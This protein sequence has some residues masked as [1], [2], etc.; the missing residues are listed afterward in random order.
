MK[1]NRKEERIKLTYYTLGVLF[2]LITIGLLYHTTYFYFFRRDYI[3]LLRKL[4][5]IPASEFTVPTKRYFVDDRTL[6]YLIHSE[7]LIQLDPLYNEVHMYH[8]N[9]LHIKEIV[10]TSMSVGKYER[11]VQSD[12]YNHLFQI[13]QHK[14][15]ETPNELKVS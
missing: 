2:N 14:H 3:I 8:E 10:T 12:V 5:T 13:Y 11:K 7:V 4:K 15:K 1:L 6:K 9:V